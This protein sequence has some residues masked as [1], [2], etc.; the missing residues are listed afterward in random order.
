M[1]YDEAPKRPTKAQLINPTRYCTDYLSHFYMKVKVF[2]FALVQVYKK[3]Q[4]N[5]FSYLAIINMPSMIRPS[6]VFLLG[7]LSFT[8]IFAQETFPGLEI[9]SNKWIEAESDKFSYLYYSLSCNLDDFNFTIEVELPDNTSPQCYY[10]SSFDYKT[11]VEGEW[12]QASFDLEEKLP[13]F[14]INNVETIYIRLSATKVCWV[15]GAWE[16]NIY[17]LNFRFKITLNKLVVNH[18]NSSDYITLGNRS[19]ENE[20]GLEWSDISSDYE[21]EFSNDSTF[22]ELIDRIQTDDNSHT[23]S[24]QY[25]DDMLA[26]QG[27]G[28]SNN[29]NAIYYKVIGNNGYQSDVLKLFFRR[30]KE[31]N[32]LTPGDIGIIYT[33]NEYDFL[34]TGY[35]ASSFGF[36]DLSLQRLKS[37]PTGD[38]VAIYFG[39]IANPIE[40]EDGLFYAGRIL[41]EINLFDFSTRNVLSKKYNGAYIIDENYLYTISMR[42]SNRDKIYLQQIRLSD[43]MLLNTL[44]IENQRSFNSF[45]DGKDGNLYVTAGQSL[46]KINKELTSYKSIGEF[47]GEYA[48]PGGLIMADGKIYGIV[49]GVD[50]FRINKNGKN[51][52]IYKSGLISYNGVRL[53]RPYKSSGGIIYYQ[54]SNHGLYRLNAKDF[55]LEALIISKKIGYS[56]FLVHG[57]HYFGNYPDG[58]IKIN[59]DD[60][61]DYE[62][63]KLG[64]RTDVAGLALVKYEV[65][66]TK[67]TK[68]L[69]VFPNPA[70]NVL[71][72]YFK[73]N[74]EYISLK[75]F[76]LNI[77]G[78]VIK[79]FEVNSS[80]AQLDVSDIEP[81]MYVLKY[82]GVLDTDNVVS[83]VTLIIE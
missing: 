45:I 83:G 66:T 70:N 79:S 73:N 9:S 6:F 75:M 3:G 74:Y 62:I 1:N 68:A 28:Y 31:Y 25:F 37:S 22:G 41:T 55:S 43:E 81:G 11:S 46:I 63:L 24:L 65:S 23:F 60:K 5:A 57:N 56:S 32:S 16:N 72:I 69:S 59:I 34:G 35:V 48:N 71:N 8:N 20:F 44:Y 67:N 36:F 54:S 14:E 30:Y 49:N 78:K 29:Y 7:F 61:N 76:V 13:S 2:K 33:A 4:S 15:E 51:Q 64:E 39:S 42:G 12:T 21:I 17:D 52:K 40:S 47:G 77:S 19:L 18:D 53:M 26:N 27:V 82:Q 58:I 50:L 80:T 10:M 38:R